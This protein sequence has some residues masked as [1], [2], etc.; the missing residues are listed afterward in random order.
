MIQTFINGGPFMAVL[1]LCFLAIIFISAKNAKEPFHTNK[2]IL[3]GV[4]SA[5]LGIGATWLGVNAAL[6]A[7]PDISKI[8]PHILLNGVKTG[9]ITTYFG[10]FVLVTATAVWYYFIKKHNLLVV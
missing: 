6:T 3:L 4:A 2:I 7:V 9:L 8:A 10:G 5:F 1:L